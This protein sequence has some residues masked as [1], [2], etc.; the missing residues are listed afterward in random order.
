MDLSRIALFKTECYINGNWVVGDTGATLA[1]KNPATGEVI[2]EVAKVGAEET[3]RAI[4]AAE[5]AMRDWRQVPAKQRASILRNWF[6]L[7]MENQED[8]ARIMTTEQ[9]KTLAESRGE[10]AY[11][12]SYIEWFAEQAKRIDGDVI[13]SPGPDKR[14][15]CIKQPVGVCAAITPWNFP[16]AMITRKAAPALAAGCSIVIK[17]ASETPLSALALAELAERAGIPAGVLNVVVGSSGEIGGELTSNPVVR[18]LSFTGSTPVG[19]LLEAQCAAT[20]KKTSMELGGNAPFIVFDDADIGAAVQGALIS[21]YRNSGQTCVCSNRLLVQENIA[22]EF[23]ARLAKATAA[24]TLGNGLNEEVNLGPLVNEG[25]VAD[26]DALVQ[27]TIAAGATLVLGG[28]PSDLGPCFY[29]PTILTNVTTD[30]PVFRN[31]I[32]GPVAPIIT[33]KDEAEAIGLANDTEFGLASYFYTRDIGRVWRVA[34]A[35]EYGIV[36]INEG[37]ISNEMAPFGGVKESGSGR[38][39]SKYGMDDYLEIKYM[40]MGGLDR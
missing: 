20:M 29:Q 35:L 7:V 17:P 30:M 23:T 4:L 24:L 15:V 10:V 14:I 39:G 22:E 2:A 25:A 9:G 6:N 33:F 38:E 28:A 3:R 13:P 19:K 12:A 26:V 8:L 18:K 16:N 21:K 27:Q 36:G 40:L 37:I 11:G 31:E 1:V 34:E 32:F 5:T